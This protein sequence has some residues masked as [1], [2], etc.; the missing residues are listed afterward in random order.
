[1][2]NV[3]GSTTI[4]DIK[5]NPPPPHLEYHFYNEINDIQ[6]IYSR[7]MHHELFMYIFYKYGH[8]QLFLACLLTD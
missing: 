7:F 4:M 2:L 5:K 3:H 6:K 1:M 8:T